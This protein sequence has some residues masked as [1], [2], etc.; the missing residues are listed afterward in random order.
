M[1]KRGTAAT[2]A[3]L[4]T[5]SHISAIHILY[6]KLT[7]DRNNRVIHNA[8]IRYFDRGGGEGFRTQMSN[9]CENSAISLLRAGFAQGYPVWSINSWLIFTSV[10]LS[11]LST[12][13][14]VWCC[15][16]VMRLLRGAS[17]RS[18]T[19]LGLEVTDLRS[20]FESLVESHKRLASRYAMR[21]LRARRRDGE[22]P[23]TPAATAPN[24]K[25]K[26]RDLARSRGLLR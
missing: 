1:S 24:D 26:L 16:R 6:Q 18:L 5:P 2:A 21:E 11:L 7:I 20:Q 25:D 17:A 22:E 12:A 4:L 3:A 23:D 13:T 19:S 9:L 8:P 15:V 14:A 10:S